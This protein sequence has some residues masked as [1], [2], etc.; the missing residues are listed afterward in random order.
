[1]E[2]RHEGHNSLQRLLLCFLF[3]LVLGCK[4]TPSTPEPMRSEQPSQA[5]ENASHEA[6]PQVVAPA[7]TVTHHEDGLATLVV[8]K[9]SSDAELERL[10]WDLRLAFRDRTF[11]TKGISQTLVDERSPAMSFQIYRGPRCSEENRSKGARTCGSHMHDAATYLLGSF[12]SRDSESATLYHGDGETRAE[13]LFGPGLPPPATFAELVDATR[14]IDGIPAHTSR[15][16]ELIQQFNQSVWA[17]GR[18]ALFESGSNPH[19]LFVTADWLVVPDNRHLMQMGLMLRKAEA[20]SA[21]FTQV[22]LRPFP[23]DAGEVVRLNCKR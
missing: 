7:F 13:L 2:S 9:K 21:N 1:M 22:R 5:P 6:A 15:P 4:E 12:A 20:C 10:I 23:S 3:M 16:E 19:E 18:K 8:S 17:G 11:N 14:P